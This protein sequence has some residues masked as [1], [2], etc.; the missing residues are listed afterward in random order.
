MDKQLKE[1]INH[2]KDLLTK[3][4]KINNW[5]IETNRKYMVIEQDNY[6]LKWK[7]HN[8]KLHHV[9]LMMHEL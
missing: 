7:Q 1:I 4:D 3:S 2:Y 8:K 6:Y 9:L 5:F